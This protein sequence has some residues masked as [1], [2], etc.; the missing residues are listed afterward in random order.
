[1]KINR[2]LPFLLF[3]LFCT[4]AVALTKE[5]EEEKEA[6]GEKVE[7]IRESAKDKF[8][9]KDTEVRK[10]VPYDPWILFQELKHS[11]YFVCVDF[12]R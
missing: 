6:P 10:I 9:G 8:I 11:R 7:R 1:M 4:M 3:F 5:E 2:V 12:V